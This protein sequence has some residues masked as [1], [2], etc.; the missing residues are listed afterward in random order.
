MTSTLALLTRH[1]PSSPVAWE[2]GRT[3]L[4]SELSA[5]V[6]GFAELL[7]RASEGDEIVVICRDRYR[8]TVALLAAWQRGYSVALPPNPQ[9]E[10][11]R[12]MRERANVKTVVHDVDGGQGIDVRDAGVVAATRA[13]VGA[14]PFEPLAFDRDRLLA[15]VY[16]SGST[17]EHAAC[18][19]TAG[20]ILGEAHV[21]T[22]TFALRRGSRVLA[23]VPPYHIYGLLFGVLVPLASGGALYRHTPLHAEEVRAVLDDGADVLVTVPAHL[24][25]LSLAPIDQPRAAR[26]FSS[27]APLSPEVAAGAKARFGWT[28]TEVFGSSET[29][30]IGWRDSGGEGPWT[31]LPG[32]EV[33]ATDDDAIA[34]RS[35]FLSPRAASPYVGA[36]RVAVESDGR[37]VHLGRADGV[38]KIG[39][40]RVSLAE[41]ERRTCAIAGVRDAAVLAVDVGGARGHEV[42]VAVVAPGLDK[43]AIRAALREW[44]A[45]VAMP[46]RIKL[47]GALPREP[48]GKLPRA[49]LEALFSPR[50][51]S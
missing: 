31:P 11:L 42:W 8:F 33:S 24:R 44:L 2:R 22:E 17:G 14:H 10:T 40:V 15:T 5:H 25:A 19:K 43:E 7:P 41:I 46:R 36:D 6:A 16:T 13:K 30:G 21:L 49:S 34:I 51:R 50:R 20:Q 29:G 9:P 3:T 12:V 28:I 26:V 38:L 35:P 4:A 18:A 48:N 27:G 47:V 32:V 1:E 45:P 39:G 23:M 37:F